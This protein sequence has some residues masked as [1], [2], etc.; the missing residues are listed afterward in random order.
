MASH[1]SAEK[2]NRQNK[3]Q[4]LRNASVKTLVKTKTRNVLQAVEEKEPGAAKQALMEAVS[5]IDKA[6]K[7]VLH[8]NT[9]SRKISRLTRKVNAL[10]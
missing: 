1:K 8:R 5:A 3:V 4:R 6:A 2:R 7:K 9:A 10:V